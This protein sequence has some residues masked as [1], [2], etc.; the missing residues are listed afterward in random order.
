MPNVL[1]PCPKMQFIDQNGAPYSG[2]FV[3]T[4]QAGTSIQLATYTDSTGT[5]QN[6]NPIVLDSAGRADIWLAPAFYRM[7]LQDSNGVQIYVEDNIS[8]SNLPFVTAS[9]FVEGAA[10]AGSIGHDVLYGDLAS[11][12]LGLVNNGGAADL[13]VTRNSTDTLTNKTLISP[14]LQDPTIDALVRLNPSYLFSDE[15]TGSDFSARL[16]ACV[17]ALPAAGGVIDCRND[18]DVGGLGTTPFDP[19][20]KAITVLFGAYVYFLNSIT[21]RRSL[22]LIGMGPG[23]NLG[24]PGTGIQSKS[25]SN[26]SLVILPTGPVPEVLIS[27]INFLGASGNTTQDCF[28]IVASVNGGGLWYSTFEDLV[29]TGFMGHHFLFDGQSHGSPPGVNQFLSFRDI[30][31]VRPVGGLSNLKIIGMNGQFTFSRVEFDGN[32]KT[33]T[34]IEILEGSPA[35]VLPPYNIEFDD[36]TFQT[37]DVGITIAGANSIL[38]RGGHAES[39]NGMIHIAQGATFG[40]WGI[41]VQGLWIAGTVGVNTGAGYLI[42]MS[43]I[44][45]GQGY[46]IFNGNYLFGVPNPDANFIPAAPQNISAFGNSGPSTGTFSNIV[47]PGLSTNGSGVKHARVTTGSIGA[48]TRAS[49]TITWT[50]AFLDNNYS[51]IAMIFDGT[52]VGTSQGLVIERINAQIAASIKVT[53][54]NPTGGALTGTVNAFAVHD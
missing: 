18:S 45:V 42:D 47:S 21:L 15:A 9:D 40:S 39:L 23:D 50:T 44:G 8:G 13:V 29:I 46:V 14:V 7:I 12:R 49:V 3:F 52:T 25:A 54:F 17:T 19:G 48:G 4:Y 38:I 37:A 5:S 30:Y 24:N 10:P 51:P 20:T 28:H 53:V 33:G 27:G 31:S 16:A 26:A 11:H 34:N 6:T 1:T 41:E 36:L 43:G 2:G 22:R 35:P 32:S